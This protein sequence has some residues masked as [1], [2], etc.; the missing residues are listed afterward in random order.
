MLEISKSTVLIPKIIN[1]LKGKNVIVPF[2]IP[3]ILNK[4]YSPRASGNTRAKGVEKTFD[5]N[6]KVI[7]NN[8]LIRDV[9][10]D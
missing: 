6:G 7:S 5:D 1:N 3:I 9:D 4:V 8:D 2:K 10:N